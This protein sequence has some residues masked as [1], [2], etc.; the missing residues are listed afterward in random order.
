MINKQHKSPSKPWFSGYF[1]PVKKSSNSNIIKDRD[2]IEKNKSFVNIEGFNTLRNNLRIC[3]KK[4]SG[5]R[6]IV[7]SPLAGDGK[8]T[9]S[10]NLAISLAN[11][12]KKVLIIDCD[13]RKP[14]I[15][16][17]FGLNNKQGLSDVLSSL[18]SVSQCIQETSYSNLWAISAGTN[19]PNPSELLS[20]EEMKDLIYDLSN[21]YDY[22]IFDCPP[23]NVVSDALPLFEWVDGVILVIRY[24]KTT[25]PEIQKAIS[26]INFAKA[27]LF[28]VFFYDKPM[29]NTKYGYKYKNKYY[30]RYYSRYSHYSYYNK[31]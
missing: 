18:T 2:R 1:R 15:H 6:V 8:S 17:T 24:N 3:L 29:Q 19:A 21:K 5:N 22:I 25:H 7:T 28:G 16:K 30:N 13:L 4:D 27:N 12:N 9:C 20:S 23:I 10:S 26:V 11:A 31:E 14:V